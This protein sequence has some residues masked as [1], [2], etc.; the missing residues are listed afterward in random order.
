MAK[1][2]E[3]AVRWASI[4][5]HLFGGVS[6]TIEHLVK[7]YYYREYT[8][9]LQCWANTTRKPF[10]RIPALKSTKKYPT[11]EKILHVIWV[12]LFS[13][14]DTL[15]DFEQFDFTIFDDY[16]KD[17]VKDFNN[18]YDEVPKIQHIDIEGFRDFAIKYFDF[19][20]DLLSKNGRV[21]TTQNDSF[22][23]EY[24]GIHIPRK[25]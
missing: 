2:F 14:D 1:I 20:A 22:L 11:K 4:R 16:H 24:L 5:N 8:E 13:T 7:L 18:I 25:L 3:M 12:E 9:Y 21:T 23:N 6:T 17:T 10:E 15:L 19:I